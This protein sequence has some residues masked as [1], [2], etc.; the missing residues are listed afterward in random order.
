MRSVFPDDLASSSVG[1]GPEVNIRDVYWLLRR[2]DPLR[3]TS[4]LLRF[5]RTP[6]AQS[7]PLP[8]SAQI[9]PATPHPARCTM[10]DAARTCRSSAG[11]RASPL[12]GSDYDEI[13]LQN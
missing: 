2:A 9:A 4:V 6:R 10:D 8:L 5:L 12:G 7:P 3:L 11:E 13:T 1:R